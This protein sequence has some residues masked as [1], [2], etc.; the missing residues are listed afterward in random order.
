MWQ[1]RHQENRGRQS[2]SHVMRT[3]PPPVKSMAI[4]DCA[5]LEGF[6]ITKTLLLRKCMLTVLGG[7]FSY[8]VCIAFC[9]PFLPR[10]CTVLLLSTKR[11]GY[12]VSAASCMVLH[13]QC[14]KMNRAFLTLHEL[15]KPFHRGDLCIWEASGLGFLSV[16]LPPYWSNQCD[17]IFQKKS[18]F[19]TAATKEL[20][21]RWIAT[22]PSAR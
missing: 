7:L 15:G 16:K 13:M 9:S 14:G 22:V 11:R 21:E 8:L 10:A 19:F 5:H 3:P 2:I 20:K 1:F 6:T 18:I 4:P 12:P 17:T